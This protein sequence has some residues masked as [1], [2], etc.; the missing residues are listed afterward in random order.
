MA[1]LVDLGLA[2]KLDEVSHLTA[3]RQGFGT[4]PY[5]PYEQAFMHAMPMAAATSTPWE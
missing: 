1:K 3:T 5:M 4:T 2:K